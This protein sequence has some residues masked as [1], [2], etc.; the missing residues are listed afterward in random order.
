MVVDLLGKSLKD[1][2]SASRR[3]LSLKTVLVLPN[4]MLSCV[5]FIHSKNFVHRDDFGSLSFVWV[6]LLPW[7]GLMA[8][9]QKQK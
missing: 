2:A 5:W 6:D 8:R 7:M 3:P 1:I 9:D 4:Q